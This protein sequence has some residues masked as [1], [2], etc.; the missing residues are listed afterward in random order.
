MFRETM[1]EEVNN[2]YGK[3]IFGEWVLLQHLEVHYDYLYSSKYKN[4]ENY[5]L[6]IN[7]IQ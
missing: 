6:T 4:Y 1:V 5:Y 3:N 2:Q 7:H